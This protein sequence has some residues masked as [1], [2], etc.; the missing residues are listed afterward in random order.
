MSNLTL[1][2]ASQLPNLLPEAAG[3]FKAGLEGAEN[4]SR[5]YGSDI[6]KFITWCELREELP[7]P[8]SLDTLIVYVTELAAEYKFATIQRH[9]AAINK[10]HHV[11]GL[12]SPSAHRQF[13]IFLEGIKRTKGIRQ[14]QAPAFE[15]STFKW[16]VSQLDISTNKGLR[17]K[18]LLLLG[19][20]GAFRRSELVSLNVEHLAF[21]TD[22]LVVTLERSKTN[23]YGD[24]EEK[25]IYFSPNPALCPIRT[26][27]AWIRQLGRE[28]GP[29]FVSLKKTDGLTEK[30]LTDR[31]VYSLVTKHLGEKY[32]AHSLRA[33]FVTTAKKNGA[34][35]SEIMR[36][37]KHKTVTM[38]QRYTRIE[39]I[40]EHNA[41]MKLGL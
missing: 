12:E 25:A 41:A 19:F 11:Q 40:K 33:S 31:S 5:A 32:A 35:D 26:L 17:D 36:Q 23:Q 4:T 7:V 1:V 3:Y 2:T 37:T 14:K 6:R 9:L 10:L 18:A 8:A 15:L 38:I 34:A 27:Q 13:K 39:D 30:R 29:L 24:W 21:N 22:C 28:Q 20:T 16:A